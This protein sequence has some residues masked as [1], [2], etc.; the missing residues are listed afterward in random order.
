MRFFFF[1]CRII[2]YRKTYP[3]VILILSMRNRD[4]S[5]GWVCFLVQFLTVVDV[6]RWRSYFLGG[7]TLAA[8]ET[9]VYAKFTRI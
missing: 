3:P 1:S 8:D 9:Q 4:A 5:P 2:W 6:P 7:I